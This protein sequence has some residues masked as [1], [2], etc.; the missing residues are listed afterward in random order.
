M[1]SLVE[2]WPSGS[3][4]DENVKSLKTDRGMTDNS[5]SIKVHYELSDQMS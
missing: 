2:I 5:R 4:E 3:G 1:T